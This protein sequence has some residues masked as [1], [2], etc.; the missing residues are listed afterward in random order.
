[1][2]LGLGLLLFA[3]GAIL[4]FAV[5]Y[6]VTGLNLSMVGLILMIVGGIA[7]VASLVVSLNASRARVR[8]TTVVRHDGPESTTRETSVE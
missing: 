8:T 6:S 3:A 2:A 4:R 1:M 7:F 5:D